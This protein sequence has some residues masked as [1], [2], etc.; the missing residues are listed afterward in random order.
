VVFRLVRLDIRDRTR[1]IPPGMVDQKFRVDTEH[2]VQKIF[3]IIIVFLSEGASGDIPHRVDSPFFQFFRVSPAHT[4]EI[5]QRT[6]SPQISPVTHLIQFCDTHSVRVRFDV[7]C[8]N[9]HRDLCKVQI[10]SDPRSRRNS[11]FFLHIPDHPCRQL[12]RR[13][14]VCLKIGSQV[15]KDL[16]DR[17][18]MDIFR[19]Y[20]F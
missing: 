13:H 7:L 8:H 5:R 14:M 19:C 12:M 17:I 15:D 2:P 20:I 6:V 1:L 4:P 18:G 9:I 16:I 11:G 3:V 10:R